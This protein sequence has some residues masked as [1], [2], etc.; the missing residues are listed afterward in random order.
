MARVTEGELIGGGRRFGI[1][2]SRFNETITKALLDGALNFLRRA[3]VREADIEVAW[4]PGSFEIPVAAKQMAV[5]KKFHALVV[6]GCVIRGETSNYVHIAQSAT[7]AV[8]NVMMESL[9]PVGFGLLT[10]DSY[11]Q[12]LERAGG[13]FGNR[14]R[15]AA[16]SALEMVNLMSKLKSGEIE[17]EG[18]KLLSEMSKNWN[19]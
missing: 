8:M 4:V 7:D 1:I 17:T 14:G 6:L 11:E 2:V 5:S 9:M 10:V 18:E 12:A 3:G 15:E 16:E 13:K 19:R